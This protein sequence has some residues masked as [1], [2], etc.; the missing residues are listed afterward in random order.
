MWIIYYCIIKL[1]I[2]LCSFGWVPRDSILV[3]TKWALLNSFV[4]RAP[5]LLC[6]LGNF[7]GE[8]PR[9]YFIFIFIFYFFLNPCF[10]CNKIFISQEKIKKKYLGGESIGVYVFEDEGTEKFAD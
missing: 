10:P 9:F 7:G 4:G 3:L 2:L 1:R 5:S 8:E 6:V